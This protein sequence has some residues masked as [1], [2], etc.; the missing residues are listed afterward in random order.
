MI[1]ILPNKTLH[2]HFVL[3]YP[4]INN[5]TTICILLR[6]TLTDNTN[7][8]KNDISVKH[9]NLLMQIL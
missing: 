1:N 6:D 7:V 2:N 8:I 5:H 4:K 3:F 9:I